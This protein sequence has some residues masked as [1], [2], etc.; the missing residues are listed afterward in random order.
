MAEN[1]TDEEQLAR[2]RSWWE[3]NGTALVVGLVL[4][5]AAVVGWR[6][7][8]GYQEERLIEA[9]ELYVQFQ[10]AEGEARDDLAARI[11]EQGTGTAYPT[12]VLFEQAAA[13]IA[14]DVGGGA[15]SAPGS[16]PGERRGA[17]G[18][19]ASASGAG[20]VQVCQR[21]RSD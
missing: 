19:G 8:E 11:I 5:V 17:G 3:E 15:A 2:L 6:W 12:F 13:A 20:A 21:H 14:G 7:Y 18:S 9:S 16:R 4:V 1:P 10:E